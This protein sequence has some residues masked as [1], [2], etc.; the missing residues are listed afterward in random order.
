MI[1]RLS[2][3]IT[4]KEIVQEELSDSVKYVNLKTTTQESEKV[5]IVT[6]LNKEKIDE[7]MAFAGYNLLV[8]SEVDSDAKDIYN[9]YHNLWRIEHSFRLM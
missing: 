7:D 9:A 3:K 8:T 4:Y 1:D 6:S 2:N 5:K